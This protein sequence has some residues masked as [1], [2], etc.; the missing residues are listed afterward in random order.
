VPAILKPKGFTHMSSDAQIHANQE[1]SKLSTGPKT[2]EGK[3]KVAMNSL[4]HGFAGQTVILQEHEIPTYEKHFA[5]FRKEY[6][7]AGPTE[8]FM[9]HS[10]ADMSYSL[11]Q[12][13]A[14]MTT[15][16]TIIGVRTIPH[17]NETHSEETATAV[18]RA[19]SINEEGASLNTLGL[20][21]QRKQRLFHA[22]RKELLQIQQARKAEEKASLEEAAAHRQADKTWSPEENGFVHSL[23][24]IDRYIKSQSFRIPLPGPTK[25]AA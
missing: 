3:R 19:R 25:I 13:R 4:K 5:D 15:K 21:E 2:P 8:E 24:E 16:M 14:A 17:D 22:T 6:K 1:N 23:D 20:Y 12:L 18:S 9:V 10:L 11:G 7:P